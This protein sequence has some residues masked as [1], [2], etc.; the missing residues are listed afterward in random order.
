MDSPSARG[1]RVAAFVQKEGITVL[2]ERDERMRIGYDKTV[3]RQSDDDSLF[4]QRS[5]KNIARFRHLIGLYIKR[6]FPWRKTRFFNPYGVPGGGEP[7][8]KL[9][10]GKQK[11]AGRPLERA[12]DAYVR[13]FRVCADIDAPRL[14][15]ASRAP[16]HPVSRRIQ[17]DQRRPD[18]KSRRQEREIKPSLRERH[19]R[20]GSIH[21]TRRTIIIPGL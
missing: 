1:I 6:F 4:F 9:A 8:N 16:I 14:F 15:K 3:D 19:R 5:Q 13:S 10:L 7:G 12:V 17:N 21:K 11:C 18:E 20:Y 2:N